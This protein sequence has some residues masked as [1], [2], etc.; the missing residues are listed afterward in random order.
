MAGGG[1]GKRA[2][3]GMKCSGRTFLDILACLN[4]GYLRVVHEESLAPQSGESNEQPL[5][6]SPFSLFHTFIL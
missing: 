1:H 3:Q 6:L 2:R 4:I 5:Q